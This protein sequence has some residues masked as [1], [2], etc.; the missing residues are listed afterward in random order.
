MPDTP[1]EV[2]SWKSILKGSVWTDRAGLALADST[3]AVAFSVV[4]ARS[5]I[6]GRVVGVQGVAEVRLR[7]ERMGRDYAVR[8]SP[9]GDFLVDGLPADTYQLWS[10]DDVNGDG[11]WD[12]G[13]LFPFYPFGGCHTL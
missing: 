12:A 3:L 6:A 2:G 4:E 1:W 11:K 8:C 9:E 5:S 7:A 13:T 10:F